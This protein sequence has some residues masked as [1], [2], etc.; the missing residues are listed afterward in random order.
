MDTL[1]L[2]RKIGKVLHGLGAYRAVVVRSKATPEKIPEMSME[3]AVDG[4][5]DVKK[6]SEYCRKEFPNVEII[7]LN[8]SEDANMD[9]MQEVI[10]DGIQI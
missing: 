10:K 9:L 8:L 2:Y 7:L 1:T 6:A 4:S 5:I 3:I